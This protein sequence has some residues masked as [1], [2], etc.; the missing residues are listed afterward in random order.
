[1]E[2]LLKQKEIYF[3][4]IPPNPNDPSESN[5]KP[6]LLSLAEGLQKLGIPFYANI[7][8]WKT[9]PTL[10][11]GSS[12]YL[13]KK[14]GKRP[15]EFAVIVAG[16]EVFNHPPLPKFFSV[17]KKNRNFKLVVY[18]WIA[19][20]CYSKY[21]QKRL[22]TID[23]CF[24]VSYNKNIPIF[25]D[26]K[27]VKPWPYGLTNRII[28]H[29]DQNYKSYSR[30]NT[31]IL[32]SHRVGHP[33]RTFVKV[34]FYDKFP[35]GFLTEYNDKFKPKIENEMDR[36]MWD[37][38]GRRHSPQFY[39]A[40]SDAKIV[41]CCGGYFFNNKNRKS[42]DKRIKNWDSY[43]LWE[44]FANACCVITLDLDYYGFELPVMPINGVEYIGIRLDK[45]S[46]KHTIDSITNREY[47]L[48]KIAK[49]GQRW[50]LAHYSP[51]NCANHLLNSIYSNV[52]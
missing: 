45:E 6:Q 5:Y 32:W 16:S 40:L 12:N 27:N 4:L 23:I 34:N 51:E 21:M 14:T 8:W 44:S 39:E 11:G 37:Q 1:M 33:I 47:D 9:S 30:R 28:Q 15:E 26:N 22:K 50:A 2:I 20:I 41:D 38:T 31:H 10:E 42:D 7:N 3:H 48:Q 19:H 18:D 43:K 35:K 17:P 36:L 52:D 49:N 13:F 24:S 46:L 29:S 25:T